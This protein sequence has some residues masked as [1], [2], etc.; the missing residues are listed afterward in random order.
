MN[1][2]EILARARNEKTDEMAIRVRDQSMRWT[3]LT[4][5]AVAALFAYLRASKGQ[6]MMDLCVTVCASVAV[7]HFYRA[8]RLHERSYLI[9][10][11]ITLLVAVLSLIRFCMGH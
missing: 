5:V 7:G 8:I 4:M 11:L 6:P 10:G 1:K 3:Y 9:I 2:S